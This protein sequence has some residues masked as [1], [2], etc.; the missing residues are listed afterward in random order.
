MGKIFITELTEI[1]PEIWRVTVLKANVP[2]IKYN[3]YK[4][5]THETETLKTKSYYILLYSK[6]TSNILQ[7][8]KDTN[9]TKIRGY[10]LLQCNAT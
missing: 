2:D 3:C 1:K 8:L 5:I 4:L 10:D 6:V 9:Q 7:I